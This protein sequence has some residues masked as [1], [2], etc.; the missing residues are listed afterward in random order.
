MTVGAI[1]PRCP[2][3]KSEPTFTTGTYRPGAMF[4]P[5]HP[6]GPCQVRTD[7]VVYGCLLAQGR[8][9]R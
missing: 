7:S 9:D 1:S 3:Y 6:Y 4:H 5:A 2:Y 8:E